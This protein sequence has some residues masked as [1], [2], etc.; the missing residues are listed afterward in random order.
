MIAAEMAAYDPSD[1]DGDAEIDGDE[2]QLAN[3]SAAE[4][5]M[6]A[7]TAGETSEETSERAAEEPYCR[8]SRNH[9]L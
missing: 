9:G 2:T 1:E 8:Q 5:G 7:S 4:P 3:S 6:I